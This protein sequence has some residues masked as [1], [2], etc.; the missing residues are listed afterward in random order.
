MTALEVL[1]SV[2]FVTVKGKRFA[3]VNADGWEA[4]I[5]WLETVEDVDNAKEAMAELKAAGG[6]RENA[7]WLEWDAVEAELK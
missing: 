1:Q 7:G 6:D 2:E 5:E 4:L 3:L